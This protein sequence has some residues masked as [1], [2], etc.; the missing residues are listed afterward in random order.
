[1]FLND[2]GDHDLSYLPLAYSKTYFIH[3]FPSPPYHRR[4]G[5]KGGH[6]G[7]S[8]RS[9]WLIA[10]DLSYCPLAIYCR[11][12]RMEIVLCVLAHAILED[13]FLFCFFLVCSCQ[14]S[15]DQCHPSILSGM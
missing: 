15:Y 1:M 11:P 14:S 12:Q 4:S 6:F 3:A 5:G 13:I 9:S 7:R 10:F 8:C 2:H